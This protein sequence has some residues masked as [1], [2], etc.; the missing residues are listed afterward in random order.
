[1]ADA[2]AA[3]QEVERRFSFE[4]VLPACRG[5]T[6]CSVVVRLP[7]ASELPVVLVVDDGDN[8]GASAE[9]TF[10][11]IAKHVRAKLPDDVR[12]PIWLLRW[13]T[14]AVA[15]WLLG[16]GD[17]TSDCLMLQTG[18]GWRREPVAAEWTRQ[19]LSLGGSGPS[20]TLGSR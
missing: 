17:V 4:V 5:G 9:L 15:S 2:E 14:R 13:V 6:V 20:R 12:E 18:R 1:M 10:A 16:P 8:S 11:D 3:I 19:L 7:A